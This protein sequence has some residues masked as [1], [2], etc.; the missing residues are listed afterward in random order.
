MK[1]I[2]E[3]LFDFETDDTLAGSEAVA[4]SDVR[5]SIQR[6]VDEQPYAVLCVQGGGQPYGALVAF[7][8]SGDLRRVVFATPIATRK[9]RLLIECKR[10]ALLVDNRSSKADALMQ[11]EAVTA[12][13]HAR[14]IEDK[15]EFERFSELLVIRHA[16]LRSFV[17]AASCALF[18]VDIVRFLHVTRFQE[19]H[20][21]IPTNH[22]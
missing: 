14:L 2:D 9:Y 18:S 13:G 11:I 6:L 22:S 10:V 5:Q 12:T 7:A 17:N 15:A 3:P 20:Q 8:F 21:W 19:V 4:D 16:Y 1:S